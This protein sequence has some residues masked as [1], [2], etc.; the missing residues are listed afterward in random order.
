MAIL[1]HVYLS[2]YVTRDAESRSV[3]A[4]SRLCSFSIGATRSYQQAGEWKKETSFIDVKA[5][6]EV[7]ERMCTQLRKGAEVTVQGRL[8]QESWEADGARRS[9]L[10]VVAD[11]IQV[12][13]QP[14]ARSRDDDDLPF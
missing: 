14:K 1:N 7:A 9:R 10:V 12:I 2:G 13:S 4:G 8:Q 5:W 6:N 11:R 3:G